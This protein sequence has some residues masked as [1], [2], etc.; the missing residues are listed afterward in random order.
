MLFHLKL[1]SAMYGRISTAVIRST[2]NAPSLAAILGLFPRDAAVRVRPLLRGTVVRI[3]TFSGSLILLATAGLA[4]PNVLSILGIIFGVVW[5]G[6]VYYLRKNYVDIVVGLLLQGRI[7]FEQLEN[8]DVR[9]LLRDPRVSEN[10]ETSFREE[11]GDAAVWFA[12]LLKLADNPRLHRLVLESLGKKEDHVQ[13][14]LIELVRDKLSEED[15]PV[16]QRMRKKI[17]NDTLLLFLEIM[18]ELPH[19][20]KGAFFR[21]ILEDPSTPEKVRYIALLGMYRSDSTEESSHAAEEMVKLIPK[22]T[23]IEVPSLMRVVGR[24]NEPRFLA[25]LLERFDSEKDGLAKAYV[26]TALSALGGEELNSLVIPII[27]SKVPVKPLL[28]KAAIESL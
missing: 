3:G 6:A 15:F 5:F 8:T 1:G 11:K 27:E 20:G 24:S 26:L 28:R 7:D 21:E 19:P 22:V 18:T 23:G 2:L 25:P 10:L 16:M 17:G 9:A 12:E 14:K 4:K 13:C